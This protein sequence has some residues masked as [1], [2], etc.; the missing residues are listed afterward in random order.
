MYEGSAR[1]PV[2]LGVGT[3]VE[4]DRVIVDKNAR[5]GNGARCGEARIE[6]VGWVLKHHLDTFAQ[7]Q[8]SEFACRY[9]ADVFAVEHDGAGS[10]VDQ[11]HHHH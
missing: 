10:F 1:V 7:W 11:P 2:P 6:T 4:L 8:R 3:N 5:I 9:F